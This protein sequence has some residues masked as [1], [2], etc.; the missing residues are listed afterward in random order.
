[1][2]LNCLF[3]T[4]LLLQ[5]STW[6]IF[7]VTSCWLPFLQAQDLLNTKENTIVSKKESAVTEQEAADNK[8]IKLALEK[9][10]S[11]DYDLAID[12]LQQLLKRHSN[13]KDYLHYNLAKAYLGKE[14][15]EESKIQF[16][17]VLDY[18]PNLKLM[19]DTNMQLG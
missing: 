9:I 19:I 15:K 6:T 2:K 12:V 1:M 17:K 3:T 7:F 4:R 11:K 10:S 18:S 16:T 5:K 8:Q 13:I 14:Q